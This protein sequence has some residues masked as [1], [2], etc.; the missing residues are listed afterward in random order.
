MLDT[1]KKFWS[2]V[3]T[4]DLDVIVDRGFTAQRGE[5]IIYCL[6]MDWA[7]FYGLPRCVRSGKVMVF[8]EVIDK[9]GS[10]LP[11]RIFA[12]GL[13]ALRARCARMKRYTLNARTRLKDFCFKAR[14]QSRRTT[15][16]EI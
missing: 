3:R 12:A 16:L 14:T 13:K 10:P 6:A 15:K 4:L 7:S 2:R 5:W 1:T 9:G 8:G 11:A